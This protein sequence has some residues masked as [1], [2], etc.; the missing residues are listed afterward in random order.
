MESALYEKQDLWLPVF[1]RMEDQLV[2]QAGDYKEIAES[3]SGKPRSQNRM[4]VISILREKAELSW[5]KL[6]GKI[7]VLVE[8]N[9]VRNPQKFW[10]VN[11]FACEAKIEAI[12][13]R[14]MTQFAAMESAVTGFKK[15]GEFLTGFID[16]LSPD[17]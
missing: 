12:R 17:K 7:G 9:A 15:T 13:Q 2:N 10:I 6:S 3:R 1:V 14:Y 16:S 11:G 8:K 5:I 4:E